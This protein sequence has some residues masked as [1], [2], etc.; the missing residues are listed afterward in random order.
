MTFALAYKVKGAW[1][2][3]L[4]V[5]EETTEQNQHSVLHQ[6]MGSEMMVKKG[7]VNSLH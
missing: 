5:K 3:L 6:Q 1:Y 2:L 7:N 4:N